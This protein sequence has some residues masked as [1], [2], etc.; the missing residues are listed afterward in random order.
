MNQIPVFG[1]GDYIKSNILK[2][3]EFGQ[4][5]EVFCVVLDHLQDY[6][7]KGLLVPDNI[8]TDSIL[9]AIEQPQYKY[10]LILVL[11]Q[12]TLISFQQ[13]GFPRD[14]AQVQAIENV[15]SLLDTK[16]L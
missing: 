11:Q 13:D 1:S 9:K 6:V 10:G 3:T 4:L 14:L 7:N 5:C 2:D 8:V 12:L 16:L 15:F